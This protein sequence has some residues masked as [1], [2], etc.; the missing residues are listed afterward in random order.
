MLGQDVLSR[1]HC[2]TQ[3]E[4][5]TLTLYLDIDQNK[6]SN[7]N[8]GFVVQAEALLKDLKARHPE[9]RRL[10]EAAARVQRAVKG[11]E[12]QGR[13]ALLV[14]H[15]EAGLNEL[16]E[17]K[18]A[19][20]ASAHWR[21]GAFL[22]PLLEAMDE[23]ER[24]G[25]V[26][27]D[28][29]RARLFTVYLGDIT[30][31][32]DLLSETAQRTRTTGTDQWW[33]EKR[34]QRHHLHEVAAHAKRVVDALHDLNLAEPFD[35]LIMAGPTEAA[36]QLARL[37]PRRIHGKLLETVSLPLSATRREVL[38]R[39][40]EVQQ[41]MER[42]Q[43]EALVAALEAELHQ[44]G[45]AV[46]DLEAVVE[47]TNRGRVWKLAYVKGFTAEGGQCRSCGSFA[48]AANGACPLCGGD[49]QPVPGFVDRLSQGVLEMGG[50][51]EVVGGPPARRL[52]AL[53]SV[54][55]LLRY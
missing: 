3:Q 2:L 50:R 17:I 35:R 21:Q 16:H 30:E 7:R 51:V 20:P 47:A 1:L 11:L 8:R 12:P 33:S 53:G 25:V 36:A 9:D 26:L 24:F 49:I 14:V 54:A 52:A 15:A 45:K 22:R 5:F 38:E 4:L 29:Q 6:Q 28:K 55:A 42:V 18:I 39:V 23:H 46:V 43:E 10:G 37:L 27:T 34:Q 40:L 41:R 44:G 48:A 13:T 32:S 31:H 19:L